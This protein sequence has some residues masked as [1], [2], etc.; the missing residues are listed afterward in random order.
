MPTPSSSR[1]Q[2][3]VVTAASASKQRMIGA[4]ILSGTCATSM[5]PAARNRS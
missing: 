1:V 5:I 4:T 2:E 3:T